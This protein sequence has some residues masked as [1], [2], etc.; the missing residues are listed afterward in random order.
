MVTVTT[1]HRSSESMVALVT[2]TA[3]AGHAHPQ[4][5]CP[6]TP[7]PGG[8]LLLLWKLQIIPGK[9]KQRA[10]TELV[11]FHLSQMAQEALASDRL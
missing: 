4:T 1:V 3:I 11:T 6:A 10:A 5:S 9:C 7:G 8:P 2:P